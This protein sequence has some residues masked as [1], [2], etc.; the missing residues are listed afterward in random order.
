MSE[1]PQFPSTALAIVDDTT[2]M[3]TRHLDADHIWLIRAH[4]KKDPEILAK[5]C[6][7]SVRVVLDVRRFH[8]YTEF[9]QQPPPTWNAT[10]ALERIR[11]GRAMMRHEGRRLVG[12]EKV[13]ADRRRFS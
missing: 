12:L 3:A 8:T 2:Y 5:V 11:A 9:G 4:P 13:K 7:T 6:G 10:E 1:I